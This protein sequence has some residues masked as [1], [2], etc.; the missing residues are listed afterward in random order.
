MRVDNESAKVKGELA[1]ARRATDAAIR[2]AYDILN[3]LSIL[4]PTAE[5]TALVSVLLG[6]EERAKLYYISGGKA[7]AEP[8]TPGGEVTEVTPE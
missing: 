6:I 8:E 1:D 5:L 3:A 2:K 4:A 7:E